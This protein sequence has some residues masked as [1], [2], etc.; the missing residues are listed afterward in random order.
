MIELYQ[1]EGII[2]EPAGA[3]SLSALDDVA[4]EIKGKTVVCILSGG[5]NDILRYPEI[6]ERSLVYQ[7]RKHYF[8]IEFA[9]KP[10]QLRQFVDDAL[11]PTDDI[12]RFEYIKKTNKERG[13]ALVGIEL[14]DK[15]D[16]EPLLRRMEQIP[17]NF[18]PLGSED[19]LYDYIVYFDS[20]YPPAGAYIAQ[21]TIGGTN[22]VHAT[23]AGSVAL[24]GPSVH[25]NP[26]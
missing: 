25:A 15:A 23:D 9:Q 26:R 21:S 18:R 10:G 5:N 19:L 4:A 3:L 17:L 8:I 24:R 20:D 14:K 7:G 16:L 12:V 11:G 22:Y 2:S 6:M 13:A 1:N